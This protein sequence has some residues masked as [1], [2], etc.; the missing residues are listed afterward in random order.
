M[1][2]GSCGWSVAAAW[3]LLCLLAVAGWHERVWT[4][5]CGW[6]SRPR[7]LSESWWRTHLPV[8]VGPPQYQTGGGGWG[9]GGQ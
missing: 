6:Q 8:H 4:C 2:Q 9:G 3:V 1:L 7:A 5:A